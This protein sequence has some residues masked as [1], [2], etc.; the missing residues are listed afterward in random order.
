MDDETAA[1]RR[2]VGT[3]SNLLA[4]QYAP[5]LDRMIEL[6]G[7]EGSMHTVGSSL[8]AALAELRL[9]PPPAELERA[10]L[11][12]AFR[13]ISTGRVPGCPDA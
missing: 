4:R 11:M 7:A 12:A 2:A 5:A 10:L 1:V 9:P 6:L 13:V 3:L 8:A